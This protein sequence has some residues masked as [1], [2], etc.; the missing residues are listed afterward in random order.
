MPLDSVLWAD[1]GKDFYAAVSWSDVP[2]E[3]GRRLWLGWMNKRR[4]L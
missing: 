4:L 3:D 1:Y 2:R